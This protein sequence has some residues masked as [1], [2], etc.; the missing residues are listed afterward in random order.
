VAVALAVFVGV[1]GDFLVNCVLHSVSFPTK[2]AQMDC[3]ML[4]D[5][6][7]RVLYYL[8]T[9]FSLCILIA[10]V[11]RLSRLQLSRFDERGAV[12]LSKRN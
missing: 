9:P 5:A 11:M 3:L 1:K 8:W 4:W 6:G 12:L 7:T 10:I 2:T